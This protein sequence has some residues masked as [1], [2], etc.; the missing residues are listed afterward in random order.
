MPS[1]RLTIVVVAAAAAA[2]RVRAA[3]VDAD[4]S[5]L[6]TA[7]LSP[8]GLPP[9]TH[10][11]CG[12]QAGAVGPALRTKLQALVDAGSAFVYDGEAV[13]PDAVLAALGLMRVVPA[14]V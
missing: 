2:A 14:G 1:R 6:F 11:W 13:D 12:W 8:T 4:T 3:E 9:A 10:Y 5:N 7:G